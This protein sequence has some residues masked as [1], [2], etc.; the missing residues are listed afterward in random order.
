MGDI[1]ET[2]VKQTQVNP[3]YNLL[4]I[5]SR[6]LGPLVRFLVGSHT[7]TIESACNSPILIAHK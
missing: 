7:D 3:Q 1:G 4:L 5:G 6:G 2:L